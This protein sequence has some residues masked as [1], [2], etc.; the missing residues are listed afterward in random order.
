MVTVSNRN[1]FKLNK[2]N[3]HPHPMRPNTAV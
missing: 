2:A 3:F 1:A